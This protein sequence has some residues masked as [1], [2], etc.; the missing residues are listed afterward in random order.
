MRGSVYRLAVSTFPG[1]ALE[2]IGTVYS[3]DLDAASLPD[4]VRAQ[5]S[6]FGI[7]SFTYHSV[8]L[9]YMTYCSARTNTFLP[10]VSTVQLK[11][12]IM[13]VLKDIG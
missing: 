1:I 8:L 12:L 2:D 4:L 5:T 6:H 13:F 10:L 3:S 7:L 11:S 9:E